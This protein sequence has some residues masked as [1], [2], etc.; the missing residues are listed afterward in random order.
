MRHI[1]GLSI[2]EGLRDI[3][4]RQHMAM[5]IYD[6]QEGICRQLSDAPAIVDKVRCV[7]EAARAAGLR[8]AY[9]RHM[10]LPTA[11]MG[12]FQFRMAMA[13]QRVSDA[14]AVQPWFLRDTPGFRIVEDSRRE[15]MKRSSTNW[16]CRRSRVRRL[17]SH[18]AIAASSPSPLPALHWR[19]A[20]SRPLA[21]RPISG[22]SQYSS[23][24]P[25]AQATPQRDAVLWKAFDL[26][27]M[28]SSPPRKNFARHLRP[29]SIGER[30]KMKIGIIGAGRVGS[31]LASGWA[32]RGQDVRLGLQDLSRAPAIEGVGAD[33]VPMCWLPPR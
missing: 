29:A 21:M 18:C 10:S 13:W 24:M 19:S 6:M 12:S 16:Q 22:S 26:P 20:S 7:L 33:T 11:W 9:T 5:L 23:P 3:C 8:V 2:P 1:R 32:S 4:H 31:A 30:I 17:P 27:V 15:R 28:Q 14:E 25:A